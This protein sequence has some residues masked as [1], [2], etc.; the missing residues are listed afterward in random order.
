MRTEFSRALAAADDQVLASGRID[1]I[2][3]AV[4]AEVRAA[5]PAVSVR[6]TDYFNHSFA[7]DMV[8]RWPRENRERLL[9]V[10]PSASPSWLLDELALMAP[11][12]PMVVTLEDL[13]LEAAAEARTP[14]ATALARLDQAASA[15]DTWV[16]DPSGLASISEVR[17]SQPVLGLLSQALMRGGRGVSDGP[18]IQSLASATATGFVAA[19]ELSETDTRSAVD[20]IEGHLDAEQAGRLTRVLRAV[21]EGHGGDVA[22]FPTSAATGALTDDDLAYLLESVNEAPADFWR[23]IGRNVTTVQLGRL[24]VSDPSASLQALVAANLSTLQAKGVRLVNEPFQL[25]ESEDVPR[26]LI[27]R[28]CLALRGPNWTAYLAARKAEE[29]PPS[30][31]VAAPT[32]IALKRRAVGARVAITQVEFGRGDRALTYESRERLDVLNDPELDRVAADVGAGDVYRVVVALENGGSAGVEFS[33]ATALGPTNSTL[34]VSSLLRA[35]FPLLSDLTLE[36]QRLL[37]PV[38]SD[39]PPVDD[40]FST[41]EQEE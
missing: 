20:A 29:L 40:L 30:D 31:E 38:L 39:P 3:R 26:W 2:K 1:V 14:E 16:T 36:E 6:F 37:L 4:T 10:R 8:L 35:T 33:T 23:R 28:G 21:W 11:H 19:S 13:P 24:R 15:A 32:L 18:E 27:G 5:D 22:R 12:R 17:T 41:L 7:P 25:G 9:F 34:P